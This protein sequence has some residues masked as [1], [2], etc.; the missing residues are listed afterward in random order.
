[1]EDFVKDPLGEKT[2]LANIKSLA[3]ALRTEVYENKISKERA[4]G[5][6]KDIGL[7]AVKEQ[8]GREN[9]F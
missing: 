9:E 7:D 6:C 1:M 4:K 8:F 3:D 2:K 5:F